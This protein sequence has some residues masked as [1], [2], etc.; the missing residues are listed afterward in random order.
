V[1]VCQGAPGCTMQ[2]DVQPWSVTPEYIDGFENYPRKW[3]N[4]SGCANTSGGN[5]GLW[6][7]VWNN[8][9]ILSSSITSQ[10]LSY[11]STSM[12]AWLCGS[13]YNNGEPMNNSSSQGWFFYQ[14]ATWDLTTSVVN[15]VT[16]CHGPEGVYGQYAKAYDGVAGNV[17]ALITT[18]MVNNCTSHH[19]N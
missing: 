3:S 1:T 9:S 6:I 19:G 17:G 2:S 11:P 18:D 16:R 8:M 10:Q 4:I 13:V 7:P 5:I 14:Q 15:A 12:K